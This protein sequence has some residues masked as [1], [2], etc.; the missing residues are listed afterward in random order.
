[1]KESD[2][3]CSTCGR[4]KGLGKKGCKDFRDVM[5]VPGYHTCWRPAGTILI[6]GEVDEVAVELEDGK[7]AGE[8]G[9]SEALRHGDAE[10][11]ERSRA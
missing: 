5:G 3:R 8:D 7:A 6:W 2:K 9:A 4:W 1:M 11:A 10:S